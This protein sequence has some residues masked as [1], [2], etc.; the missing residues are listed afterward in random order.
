[1]PTLIHFL[2]K[3]IYLTIQ[4]LHKM[5]VACF[6]F[7]VLHLHTFQVFLLYKCWC[8]FLQRQVCYNYHCASDKFVAVC[9]SYCRTVIVE[10]AKPIKSVASVNTFRRKLTNLLLSQLDSWSGCCNLF[11]QLKCWFAY[12]LLVMYNCY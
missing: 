1:M 5:Q 8:S 7:K 9:H 4:K 12:L 3:H 11:C 10:F 6:V 2:E